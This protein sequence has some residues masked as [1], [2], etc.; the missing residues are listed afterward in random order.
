[1]KREIKVY[2]YVCTVT[3]QVPFSKVK[4]VDNLLKHIWAYAWVYVRYT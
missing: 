3:I 1:M 4:L 2:I